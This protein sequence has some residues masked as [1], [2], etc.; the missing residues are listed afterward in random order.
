MYDKQGR[1]TAMYDY[2]SYE[3]TDFTD[4]DIIAVDESQYDFPYGSGIERKY[5]RY[6]MP[7]GDVSFATT[8][9]LP[10]LEKVQIKLHE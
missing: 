9:Y 1:T 4:N 8:Y 6:N 7:K 10:Q 5:I 3:G 2:L